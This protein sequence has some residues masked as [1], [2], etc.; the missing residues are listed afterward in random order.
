[1]LTYPRKVYHTLLYNA[2]GKY[3]FIYFFNI[4][5]G[6]YLPWCSKVITKQKYKSVCKTYVKTTE[7]HIGN[8]I[9]IIDVY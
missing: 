9:D 5:N 6:I 8:D 1:M 4:L 2:R 7:L 3:H